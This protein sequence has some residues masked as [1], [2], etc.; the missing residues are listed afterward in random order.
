MCHYLCLQEKVNVLRGSGGKNQ[1]L[2]HLARLGIRNM[3]FCNSIS[4]VQVHWQQRSI[5]FNPFTPVFPVLEAF[6]LHRS[7]G[8]SFCMPYCIIFVKNNN[9]H[10]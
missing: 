1:D 4:T 6:I 2:W 9:K 7:P 3:S 5:I 10:M 8:R